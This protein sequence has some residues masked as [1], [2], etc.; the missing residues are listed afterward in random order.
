MDR[1]VII[2]KL[3]VKLV[4]QRDKKWLKFIDVE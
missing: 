4:W 3:D 1:K 2:K